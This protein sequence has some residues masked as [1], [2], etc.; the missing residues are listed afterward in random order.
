MKNTI[1]KLA[2]CSPVRSVEN[3]ILTLELPKRLNLGC[4]LRSNLQ[5]MPPNSLV[6]YDCQE[7]SAQKIHLNLQHLQSRKCGRLFCLINTS[8]GS[9]HERLVEWPSLQGI[10]YKGISLSELGD[11]LQ[12]VISGELKLPRKLWQP[13]FNRRRHPPKHSSFLLPP[14]HLTRR[15]HQ[16][17]EGLYAGHS[18][19]AIAHQL[20]LSEHTV[21]S[22]LYT[23][24]KKL[25]VRS[26]LEAGNWM[27]NYQHTLAESAASYRLKNIG[28]FTES[29]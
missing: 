8:E 13:L 9:L 23:A 3:T 27:R 1:R 25:G 15:E 22:H 17:L 12:R 4:E 5:Q 11:G 2:L 29:A 16:V 7:L 19:Q 18:N 24:Y 20:A 21:K 28:T 14:I 6:L 10:F 26:R